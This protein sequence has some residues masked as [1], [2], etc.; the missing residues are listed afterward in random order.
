MH[1]QDPLPPGVLG[2]LHGEIL[3]CRKCEHAGYLWE[4]HPIAGGRSSATVL[5]IGQAPGMRSMARRAHFMGPGGQLLRAWLSRG[6]IPRERQDEAVYF[7]SLTRCYPGPALR[8]AAGDRK[9]G[10][11]EI[12]L[13]AP[14]LERELALL[15]PP[16]VLLVGSMAI[17]HFLGR[18]PLRERVGTIVF[19]DSRHWLPLPHPSGVS[20]WLNDLANQ[21]LVDEGL[22]LMCALLDRLETGLRSERTV[23]APH[24]H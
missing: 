10:R 1:T 21:R 11:A 16:L 18:A 13:C 4:A 3:A 7:S 5:V 12:A 19:Q 24:S 23:S 20:R 22:A 14:Y 6:G 8:G 9:P 2:Q 17:N 15:D